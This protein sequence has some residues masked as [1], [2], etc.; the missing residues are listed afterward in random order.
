MEYYLEVYLEPTQVTTIELFCKF[1]QR[2][3]IFAF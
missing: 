1:S 2:N 3:S